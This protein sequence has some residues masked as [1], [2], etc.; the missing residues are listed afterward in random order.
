MRRHDLTEA[1][2]AI[3]WIQ[4]RPLRAYRRQ[5]LD[6]FE[7]IIDPMAQLLDEFKACESKGDYARCLGIL[8]MLEQRKWRIKEVSKPRIQT[9][10]QI[11]SVAHAVKAQ[12]YRRAREL[13]QEIDIPQVQADDRCRM[14]WTRTV[15]P[16]PKGLADSGDLD[17]AL[18]AVKDID[19]K[20]W[21]WGTV[22]LAEFAGVRRTCLATKIAF[23]LRD[24][25]VE[26][27]VG[28]AEDAIERYGSALEASWEDVRSVPDAIRSYWAQVERSARLEAEYR[29]EEALAL[30]TEVP[31]CLSAGRVPILGERVDQV[32]KL[33]TL[34]QKA[35]DHM[36]VLEERL[37]VARVARRY[38][39]AV[40]HA[41]EAVSY[42]YG[43]SQSD[44]RLFG[45]TELEPLLKEAKIRRSHARKRAI[46]ALFT[47]EMLLLWVIRR[48]RG[49]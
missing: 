35:K 36:R 12:A 31:D 41:E 3:Q 6:E 10:W 5:E 16:I 1:R 21:N 28:V 29:F 44:P 22:Q 19:T 47:G 34:K 2:A 9:L 49:T 13:M 14:E 42:V 39:Q 37:G 25:D 26:K 33:A 20:D 45:L 46:L 48:I 24:G 11:A 7:K 30:L 17:P 38:W 18:D 15:S 27:A 23:A 8:D 43:I 32:R 4:G 40:H